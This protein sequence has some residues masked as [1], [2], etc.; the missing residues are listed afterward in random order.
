MVGRLVGNDVLY[1][2][3][4][5]EKTINVYR[6]IDLLHNERVGKKN[7]WRKE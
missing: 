1:N 3:S 2:I 5:R 7:E 6:S 4:Q